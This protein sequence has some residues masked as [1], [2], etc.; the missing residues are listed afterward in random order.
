MTP[1]NHNGRYAI[2]I[3]NLNVYYGDFL[4]VRNVTLK[5]EARK[6]TALIGPSG[7]GKSTLLRSI[8]R[9]NELVGARVEGEVLYHGRNL[10]DPERLSRAG[11]TYYAIGRG[12]PA[13]AA[14][15]GEP[16]ATAAG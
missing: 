11:F 13:P 8:N 16:P 6:I 7:C 9:M 12:A 4:A 15:A 10:Y 14:A 3:R 1:S 5:I 2:D